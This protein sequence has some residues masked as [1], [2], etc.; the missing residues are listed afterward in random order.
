MKHPRK[1]Q[2]DACLFVN[3]EDKKYS[4][5]VNEEDNLDY[6]GKQMTSTNVQNVLRKLADRA[7]ID[8]YLTNHV[9]R[10]SSATYWGK[11]FGLET[12]MYWFGWESPDTA[13]TYLHHDGDQVKKNVL[14]K[15]GINQE[16]NKDL[17]E[18]KVCPR[19]GEKQPPTANYCSICSM[20]LDQEAA[21]RVKQ[22]EEAGENMTRE[23]MNGVDNEE[24]KEMIIS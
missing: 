20:S 12:M 6:K 13:K 11:E 1:D 15:A 9:M 10:H 19:C 18:Q 22:L 3:L 16:E 5:K 2:S 17:M 21:Q 14:N 8:K 7:E 23:R 4:N 24:L